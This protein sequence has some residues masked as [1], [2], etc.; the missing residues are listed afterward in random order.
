LGN[1]LREF[2]YQWQNLS[3]PDIEYGPQRITDLLNHTG[4]SQDFFRNKHCLDVGCG[5]GR[6]TWAMMQMGAHVE[7]IDISSQAVAAT[8]KI[9]AQTYVRDIMSLE[10]TQKYS[11]VL[12]WGVLHHLEKPFEGFKKVASQVKPGGTL[13][14]MVYNRAN[15]AVYEPLRRTWKDLSPKDKLDLCDKLAKERGGTVHGWW[16]ALNPQ[17]N[18]GFSHEEIREWFASSDFDQIRSIPPKIPWSLSHETRYFLRLRLKRRHNIN[19]N[20]RLNPNHE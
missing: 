6:W 15:Q 7:S 13:H 2:D 18:W 16:D 12:C 8:Q 4:L 3:S 1:E 20:G 19:M 5:V 10:P 11:F 17:Y 9:N 14:I